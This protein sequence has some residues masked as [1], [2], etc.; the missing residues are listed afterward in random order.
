VEPRLEHPLAAAVR[1]VDLAVPLLTRDPASKA[2][3]ILGDIIGARVANR[4][5]MTEDQGP[6]RVRESLITLIIL[7]DC[8]TKC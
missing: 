1:M 7:H 6:H 5:G 8:S 4:Q 2:V 3:D